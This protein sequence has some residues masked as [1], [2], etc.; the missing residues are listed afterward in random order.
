[1]AIALGLR[2]IVL[3]GLAGHR[4]LRSSEGPGA[5]QLT[6]IPSY[7]WARIQDP[8]ESTAA[9]EADLGA[10]SGTVWSVADYQAPFEL[11]KL[12]VRWGRN[13]FAAAGTDDAVTTHHFVKLTAGAP[14]ANWVEADFVAAEQTFSDFWSSL[15]TYFAPQIVLKQFRWY[16][17]GP[18][19]GPP[20]PP[21]RIVDK[22]VAGTSAS[23]GMP[24]QVA[25]SVTEKTSSPKNW[26]RFYLPPP[27][28]GSTNIG[29]ASRIGS[30][31]QTALADAADVMYEDFIVDG[32]PAVV[33]SSA[34]PARPISG[35]GTLPAISA[36][37]LGVLQIQVDDLYDVIRSRRWDAPALRLQRD[38]AGA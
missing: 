6:G 29:A 22:N 16:K 34:K 9:L 14:A 12:Q 31:L 4:V 35:G 18:S 1:M 10:S 15:I 17:A 25:L 13:S 32:H 20:N 30:A 7:L 37:A 23:Y 19:I 33:Y 21:V 3:L 26:G 5:E 2:A 8:N 11:R 27:S 36:R 38:I 24:P 28:I